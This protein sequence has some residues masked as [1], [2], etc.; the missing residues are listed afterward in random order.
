MYGNNI[1]F[2]WLSCMLSLLNH[3]CKFFTRKWE[4]KEVNYGILSYRKLFISLS[5]YALIN[6]SA[7][8]VLVL[9]TKA[10]NN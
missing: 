4:S 5:I 6:C 2:M 7:L 3:K 10:I 1:P 8:I 9:Q